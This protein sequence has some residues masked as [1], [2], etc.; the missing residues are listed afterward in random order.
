MVHNSCVVNCK[1]TGRNTQCKFYTFPRAI[2]KLK[3]REKRIN[4]VRRKNVDGSPWTLKPTDTICSDHFIRGKKHTRFL[5]QQKAKMDYIVPTIISAST[6][7][8]SQ[9]NDITMD[10][11]ID[12]GTDW[13]EKVDKDCLV[14]F[15]SDSNE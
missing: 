14:N 7:S 6:K 1:H 5:N 15:L 13:N 8:T 4:A 11:M 2:W 9:N 10:S 12:I 3:R